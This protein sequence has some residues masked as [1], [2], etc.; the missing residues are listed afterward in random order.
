MIVPTVQPRESAASPDEKARKPLPAAAAVPRNLARP[1][2]KSLAIF[3]L[4]GASQRRNRRIPRPSGTP[5]RSSR[6]AVVD[7]ATFANFVLP[8]ATQHGAAKRA[9][10]RLMQRATQ[11]KS[12]TQGVRSAVQRDCDQH[13]RRLRV[14]QR[15]P[16]IRISG[17]YATGMPS[18]SRPDLHQWEACWV[19]RRRF[20]YFTLTC[21]PRQLIEIPVFSVFYSRLGIAEIPGSAGSCAITQVELFARLPK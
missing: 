8:V 10:L 4:C 9:R 6:H 20:L 15:S 14:F 19:S 3:H 7:F 12:C 5:P 11:P 21:R 17:G 18:R 1:P 2:G 13:Q 16:T